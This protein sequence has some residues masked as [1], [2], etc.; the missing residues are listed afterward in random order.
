ML[1]RN[2]FIGNINFFL[3]VI[4]VFLLLGDI[5][6]IFEIECFVEEMIKVCI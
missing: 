5:F 6:N 4:C 1:G 2:Y 3:I